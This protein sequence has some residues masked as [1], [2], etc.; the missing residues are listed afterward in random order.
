[1]LEDAERE[2]FL[3]GEWVTMNAGDNGSRMDFVVEDAAISILGED[4]SRQRKL[5]CCTLREASP[6]LSSC[7][8]NST[9]AGEKALLR[10]ARG[11]GFWL[12]AFLVKIKVVIQS[13]AAVYTSHLSSKCCGCRMGSCPAG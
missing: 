3:R 1:M 7:S 8:S 5:C 2:S 11:V 13:D 4:Q 10:H 12:P 9:I 6:S